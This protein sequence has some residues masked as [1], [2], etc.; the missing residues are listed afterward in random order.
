[1][2][3]AGSLPADPVDEIAYVGRADVDRRGVLASAVF[4]IAALT[5]PLAR[6]AEA[7][8]RGARVRARS[9]ATIGEAEVNTVREITRAF[10]T[11]D[12]RLGGGHA[13]GALIEYLATDVMAYCRATFARES[14]RRAMF[15]AAAELAY[16][17]GWKTHDLQLEGLSQRYYL[18]AYQLAN[19]S[20]PGPHP[21]YVLRILAHQAFDLGRHD[22]CVDLAEAALSRTAGRVDP[23]TESLF[24]TTLARAHAAGG[25]RHATRSALKRAE[26]LI[27]RR[28]APERPR[29]AL[30]GGDAEARWCHQAGKALVTLGDLRAAEAQMRHSARR[31][32]P[33]THPR[34]YALTLADVA[35]VQCAQGKVEQAC[36]TWSLALDHMSGVHSAR[37]RAAVA[38]MRSHLA[39][40]R[41]RG[42]QLAHRLDEKAAALNR[43]GTYPS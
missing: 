36:H 22:H 2:F 4:S 7:V 24:W 34:V 6:P 18:Y 10:N 43:R 42:L 25:D 23:D 29:W 21:A 16:L 38:S 1:V 5:L 32:D 13:R 39:A 8:E 37:T 9:V 31:W 15:G 26:R 14:T 12:E 20:D 40:Y 27:D 19:E 28:S 41:G 33:A 17:A 30:A 3:D 11:A 35:E